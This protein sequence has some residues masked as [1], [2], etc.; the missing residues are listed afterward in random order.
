MTLYEY[1]ERVL[2]KVTE[3]STNHRF[4][5]HLQVFECP[6]NRTY[7]GIVKKKDF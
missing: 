3:V 2:R 7:F 4:S 1:M 6:N 5:S